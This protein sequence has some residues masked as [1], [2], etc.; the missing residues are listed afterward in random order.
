MY[1]WIARGLI[2]P[3][4]YSLRGEHVARYRREIQAFHRLSREEMDRIQWQKLQSLL[5]YLARDNPYYQK[6]FADNNVD[7][8]RINTPEEFA[9]IPLLTKRQVQTRGKDMISHTMMRNSIRSTSGSTGEP[10]RFPK[11]RVASA[12]MDAM[13]HEVYG[14]HGVE[15]GDRQSRIWG[16]SINPWK[17][18]LVRIKDRLFNHRRLVFFDLSPEA[19][20]EFYRLLVRFRPVSLYGVYN[21]LLEFGRTLT[22]Q[23]LRPADIGLTALIGTAEILYDHEREYLEK[24]YECPV[25]NE[26]GCTETGIIAIQCPHGS[27]HLMNHNLYVEVVDLD[28]HEV[29]PPG[30]VG[31]IVLTELH[32]RYMPFVRYRVGD[33]GSLSPRACPCGLA[34]PVLE[35]IEGRIATLIEAPDGSRMNATVVCACIP[36]EVTKYRVIQRTTE[37]I[38]V[39]VT[40]DQQLSDEF[41]SKIRSDIKRHMS[42]DMNVDIRQVDDIPRDTSGKIR[43]TISDLTFKY[44]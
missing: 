9:A 3:T 42:R 31:T 38:E 16:T 36:I 14:W 18:L 8:Q 10:L 7:P 27:M 15:M 41:L 33:M 34:S 32:S 39:L 40:A 30:E 23:G 19:N 4:V 5:E 24:T 20:E 22:N 35:N 12:Y 11:D 44:E 37:G 26:Y 25:V 17:K 1:P 6:L 2:Y 21:T 43:S 29:L 13:M 28:T